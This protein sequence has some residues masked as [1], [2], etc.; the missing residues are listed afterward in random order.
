[1]ATYLKSGED[2]KDDN[3]VKRPPLVGGRDYSNSTLLLHSSLK[4]QN[5][6][7]HSLHV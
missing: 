4:D 5:K 1:M 7:I 6:G 2:V 3:I